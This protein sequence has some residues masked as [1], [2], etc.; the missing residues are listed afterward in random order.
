MKLVCEIPPE[1]MESFCLSRDDSLANLKHQLEQF[2][3]S[4]QNYIILP[5]GFGE[6]KLYDL[7]DPE[8]EV[9]IVVKDEG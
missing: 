2:M 7:E 6:I 8:K 1:V 5:T 9:N 4:G 3:S